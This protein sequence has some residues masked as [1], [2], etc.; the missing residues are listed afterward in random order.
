M[1]KLRRMI[2]GLLGLL[3]F[4]P[5]V[6]C[7]ERPNIVFIYTDDQAPTATG[8]SGNPDLKTP[9]IDRLAASGIVIPNAFTVTPVCS[10]SRA[11]LVTGRYS[12]EFGILDWIHPTAEAELGLDPEAVTWM[13]LLQQAGYATCLSG[14]WHLGTED[15]FH[16][17]VFGYDEFMGIRDGGC[18]P[19]DPVLEVNGEDVKQEGF[20][21]DLVTDYALDFMTRN[22]SEPFL[23]SIHYRE[24]HAAWLPTRDEDWEPYRDL[25]PQLPEP[26]HPDLDVERVKKMTREYYASVA[27]VDRNVGRI[28]DLLDELN[29]S[30]NTIVV[31]TSDHGY[32]NGHHGLWFKGNAHWMLNDLPE[33]QW[34]NIDRKRRPNLYDQALRVPTVIRWPDALPQGQ[35]VLQTMTNLDWFPTLLGMADIEIPNGLNLRGRD[36][37]PM[38]KGLRIA[39]PNDLYAEYSMRHGAFVD[40][41][42]WRTHQWKLVVDFA[43]PGRDE[44]YDLQ[45]DSGELQNLIDSDDP[46][47][48]AVAAELRSKILHRL[49]ELNDPLLER[50]Q[51]ESK[52]E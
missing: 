1:T 29:L 42:C 17:T 38:L 27:S 46:A 36:F 14:K 16:P 25:D 32:H 4:L 44:L 26:S 33:Q 19:K 10:P 24:P 30:E 15:R 18:P 5:S 9:N 52:S 31:Y 35:T 50:I 6:V 49:E 39:W 28:L 41:R 2:F 8:F 47:I 23:V 12:T 51:N 21:V 40:M 22:Q 45:N 37:T 20:T 34:D 43:N 3:L 11:G 13:E 48:Q 7:A